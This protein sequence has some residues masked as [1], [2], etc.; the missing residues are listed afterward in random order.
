MDIF[1]LIFSVHA[2]FS[3][4]L[5]TLNNRAVPFTVELGVVREI[6]C[7]SHGFISVNIFLPKFGFTTTVA[8]LEIWKGGGTGGT[9]Q[10]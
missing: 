2:I 9:F 3:I 5:Y 10:V 4:L 1:M 8:Y 7:E 6:S